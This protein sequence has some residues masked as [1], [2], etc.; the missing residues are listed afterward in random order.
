MH[1]D[2]RPGRA[3]RP[4]AAAGPPAGSD[5]PQ[6][7]RADPGHRS[8]LGARVWSSGRWPPAGC[9]P[10]TVGIGAALVSAM[11]LLANLSTL[12][13]RN[14]LIRFLPDGRAGDPAADR[15][16]LRPVRGR[17]R[18]PWPRS[19]CSA[20]RCGPRSSASCATSPLAV[21]RVRRRHGGLGALRPAGPRADRPAADHLGADGERPSA[22]WPRS[23]CCRCWPSA[24]AWAIFAASRAAGRGRRR[25]GDRADPA[26]ACAGPPT[27]P[28]ADR[29]RW[30][31]WSG[32]RP[33]TT[34]RPCSGWVPPTCL[35]LMVLQRARTRGQRLL[36][37]GQHHRLHA[38]PGHQQRRQRPGRRGR[39]LPRPGRRRWPAGR[40]RNAARLVVPAAPSSACCWRPR[41]RA[42]SAPATP[43]NG[44]AA[45]AAAAALR[46]PADHR[47]RRD[48]HGPAPARPADDHRHLHRAGGH[49]PT[50]AAGCAMRLVGPD[51]RRAW[52]A[53]SARSSSP[54]RCCSPAGRACAPTRRRRGAV[55]ARAAAALGCAARR[56]PAARP[57]V[58]LAAGAG[59]LRAGRRP[60]STGC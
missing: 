27:G 41:A 46:H 36:L 19:S 54:S 11:A 10:P 18:W 29:S 1:H 9:R 24:P 30:P 57:G 35:T 59:R 44:T 31:G 56:E 15:H 58:A 13:L 12:G 14:G 53:W 45:A 25:C 39:A 20:S 5:A 2:H 52:P 33:P 55:R 4:A 21:A 43:T 8:D 17:P 60:P 26:P 3:G 47:R 37:H 16:L 40:L 51:R 34:S 38:V 32:S 23:P 48:G 7:V 6:R 42:C 28:D 22:R 49:R 50:A